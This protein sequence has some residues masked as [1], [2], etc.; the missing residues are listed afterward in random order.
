MKPPGKQTERW[1]QKLHSVPILVQGLDSLLL[2][3]SLPITR[4][5]LFIGDSRVKTRAFY[6]R[7]G[8]IHNERIDE[9]AE[10]LGH[11]YDRCCHNQD[12]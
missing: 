1:G 2:R 4:V 12:I 10:R 5:A 9:P 11:W 7:S 6:L 3:H 8:A